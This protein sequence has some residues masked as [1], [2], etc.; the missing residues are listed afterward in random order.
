MFV[1]KKSGIKILDDA[2]K[3]YGSD[4]SRVASVKDAIQG[5]AQKHEALMKEPGYECNK[6]DLAKELFDICM[7]NRLAHFQRRLGRRIAEEICFDSVSMRSH[8]DIKKLDK[9]EYAW[10]IRIDMSNVHGGY[11]P[12]CADLAHQISTETFLVTDYPRAL[13]SQLSPSLAWST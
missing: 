12:P 11:S 13:V 4:P 5:L 1:L 7:A 8:K 10:D 3:E 2:I 9:P 6:E